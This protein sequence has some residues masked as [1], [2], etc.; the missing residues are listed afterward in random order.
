M[1]TEDTSMSRSFFGD[2]QFAPDCIRSAAEPQMRNSAEL[3]SNIHIGSRISNQIVFNKL[4]FDV[5]LDAAPVVVSASPNPDGHAGVD[6]TVK[7]R[8]HP[9]ERAKLDMIDLHGQ[10]LSCRQIGVRMKVCHHVV[11]RVVKKFADGGD[12]QRKKGSG[13]RRKTT[14]QTDKLIIQAM[15]SD[16]SATAADV[17]SKLSLQNISDIT[18]LR[19][20]KE[21][22]V[23]RSSTLSEVKG[24]IT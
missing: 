5:F 4:I 1:K 24:D 22:G 6:H 14:P 10:G 7:R 8:R 20:M 18:I 13:R 11:C 12:L 17:K 15:K 3:Y 9:D 23:E 21:A 19:R 16:K 2:L